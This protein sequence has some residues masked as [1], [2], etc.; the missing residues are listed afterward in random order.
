MTSH[1]RPCVAIA[2]A[3][4]LVIPEVAAAQ[5]I[6][7]TG[8]RR[9]GPTEPAGLPPQ[10]PVVA[11]VLSYKRARLAVES[12][13]M[14]SHFS[15]PAMFRNGTPGSWTSFGAG[16][17]GEYRFN[18]FVSGTLDLTSALVGGPVATSTAEIGARI[19]R[20]RTMSRAYPFIDLRVGYAQTATRGTYGSGFS[21]SPNPARAGLSRG[22]GALAGIG[23]EF[24]LTPTLSL[25][26]GAAIMRNRMTMHDVLDPR[27]DDR[28]FTLNSYRLTLGIRWN[29]VRMMSTGQPERL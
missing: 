15:A 5:L 9:P 2:I 29:P 24:A 1:A 21:D 26:T 7:R 18:R 4:L 8:G 16:T 12:Y 3:A 22:F 17:R 14:I 20:E 19:H 28:G 27:V 25:T 10:A 23:S 11:K 6:P 13:P